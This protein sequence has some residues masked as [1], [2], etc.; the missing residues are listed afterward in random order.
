MKVAIIQSLRNA[1]DGVLKAMKSL[2]KSSV[3]HPDL[4]TSLEACKVAIWKAF[5][6]AERLPTFAGRPREIT[7]APLLDEP[8][9][10]Q[11]GPCMKHGRMNCFD[12]NE[13]L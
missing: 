13:E 12:C 10:H 8:P 9:Y 1:E 5:D 3:S 7:C 6:L 11:T 4:R 2:D